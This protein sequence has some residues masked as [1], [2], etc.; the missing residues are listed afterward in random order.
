MDIQCQVYT[1]IFLY[2]KIY[3]R[4]G[5]V[6]CRIDI[7]FQRQELEA[8]SIASHLLADLDDCLLGIGDVA[9]AKV[10]LESHRRIR[11]SVKLRKRIELKVD[12]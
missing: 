12:R 6:G 3:L 8:D 1:L 7:A 4:V 10:E 9:H 11:G 2:M 5:T